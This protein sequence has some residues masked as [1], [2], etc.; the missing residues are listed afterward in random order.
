MREAGGGGETE[1]VLG[2]NLQNCVRERLCFLVVLVGLLSAGAKAKNAVPL[3]HITEGQNGCG[4][5]KRLHRR[6]RKGSF[7]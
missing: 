5:E 2:V 6:T 4:A 3:K 7:Q 1:K